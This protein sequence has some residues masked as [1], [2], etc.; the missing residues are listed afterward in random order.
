MRQDFVK[1][2]YYFHNN[3]F[4]QKNWK[5]GKVFLGNL[6]TSC[7]YYNQFGTFRQQHLT[8]VDNFFN[9]H[10][11]IFIYISLFLFQLKKYTI[12]L[13]LFYLESAELQLNFHI[14]LHIFYFY[15]QQIPSIHHKTIF[16]F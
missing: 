13:F 15:F 10:V 2:N 7:S 9:S 11:L 3:Y 12:Y 16:H 5:G 8:T 4:F 14:T 1:N 6:S